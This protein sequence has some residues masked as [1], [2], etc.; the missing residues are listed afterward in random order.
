MDDFLGQFLSQVWPFMLFILGM[1]VL[2]IGLLVWMR[3]RRKAAQG[4]KK[5]EMQLEFEGQSPKTQKKA[6]QSKPQQ[7]SSILDEYDVTLDDE[8]DEL[9]DAPISE[10]VATL[11][12]LIDDDPLAELYQ[13][14]EEAEKEEQAVIEEDAEIVELASLL[15]G[16]GDEEEEIIY[17]RI[18]ENL[19]QVKLEGDSATRAQEHLSILR[20]ERDERLIVQIGDI[21]YRTLLNNKEAK[22]TFTK[23]M[24]E[25]SGIILK[26]D[27]NLDLEEFP[28]ED[29][30]Y[31]SVLS[32]AV[33]VKLE[34]NAE[35]RALELMSVMRDER[36]ARPMLQIGDIAYRTLLNDKEAKSVFTKTMKELAA[37]ILKADDNPPVQTQTKSEPAPLKPAMSND[38]AQAIDKAQGHY[39]E[40]N[41]PGVI[42][43]PKMDDLPST[44]SVGRFG[45]V[46]INKP[47]ESAPE[48]NIADAIEAYLQYK[49]EQT[50][51]FQGRGIHIRPALGGSIRII[52]DNQSYDFVDEIEDAE[53]RAFIQQAINEWQEQH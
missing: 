26:A 5:A 10:E 40:E 15:A 25:L 11:S 13:A 29:S 12:S 22:S 3:Q 8:L 38:V 39:D 36:D 7:V 2:Y 14:R 18:E 21:A 27:D 6:K 9:L 16:L 43:I 34:G 23:I 53:A 41:I 44:H 1:I 24:K 48:L 20:D 37:I 4:Q 50:P 30:V 17:H 35:T 42:N 47:V 19:V 51:E 49:I 52:V 32:E 46:K 31:H 45:R 33:H 28:L